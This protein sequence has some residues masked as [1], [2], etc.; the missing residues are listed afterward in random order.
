MSDGSKKLGTGINDNLAKR[1]Y[2]VL[3]TGQSN[4][5]L[6]AGFAKALRKLPPSN[7]AI[8]QLYK[9]ADGSLSI[10]PLGLGNNQHNNGM[11]A[12]M[13][14]FS[15]ALAALI[16]E[17]LD[18][19]HVV[20]AEVSVGGTG[21]ANHRWNSRGDLFQDMLNQIEWL[22][23]NGYEIILH[24]WTQGETD[25]V[26]IWA[27]RFQY[28]LPGLAC[29]ARNTAYRAGQKNAYQ[30]PFVTFDMRQAWV[31]SDPNRLLVQGVL[32]GIV[33]NLSFSGNVNSDNI[34]SDADG[35]VVHANAEQHIDMAYEFVAAWDRAKLNTVN[36]GY[37]PGEHVVLH[38]TYGSFF[39]NNYSDVLNKGTN[40]T[41]ALYSRMGD[42]WKFYQNGS[43]R[44][45]LECEHQ[46]TQHFLEW[47]QAYDPI[48]AYSARAAASVIDF[49][50]GMSFGTEG[51]GF[52]G[53][54]DFGMVGASTSP[55][56]ANAH[57][58]SCY[59]LL[60]TTNST[61][62]CPVGWTGA[63]TSQAFNW[64][65]VSGI[66]ISSA[67]DIISQFVRLSAIIE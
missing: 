44:L 60:D 50:P 5:Q 24:T 49:S 38:Q 3:V 30:I 63:S 37:A 33:N 26:P 31:G 14:D 47:E 57:M 58:R 43:L 66:P 27:Q 34:G 4:T 18:A 54:T 22:V 64:Q 17:R 8:S 48:V 1:K 32:E 15:Y 6:G 10:A 29:A 52:L 45:K 40:P 36:Y 56:T 21:W 2:A 55:A 51:M 23:A 28:L 67:P 42:L 20:V 16:R 12:A 19:D 13:I 35:D 9:D 61:F 41:D 7:G 65:G 53:L 46:G 11:N 25:A 39:A 59:T 62:W